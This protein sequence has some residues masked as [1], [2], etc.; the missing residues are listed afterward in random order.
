MPKYLFRGTRK[1]DVTLTV[2]AASPE[3]AL[4]IA[5]DTLE[6]NW[7]DTCAGYDFEIDEEIEE[8]NDA[9]ER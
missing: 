1:E 5:E 2:E 8:I 6:E 4:A 7:H 3:A 9:E